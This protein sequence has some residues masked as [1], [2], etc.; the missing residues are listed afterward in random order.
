MEFLNPWAFVLLSAIPAILLVKSA[1][2][3]FS[4]EISEKII[5]KGVISKKTKFYLLLGA[6]FLF[7]TALSRPVINNG[8]IT[9]KAPVQNVVIALDISHMMDKND[10][11]PNRYEFAKNKIRNLLTHLNSQNTALILFD[12][13][14]Y[15][16]SPPTKD[17]ESLIYLLKHTDLKDL[18]R[19]YTSDIQ[20]LVESANKLVKNP[21]IVIFTANTHIP[22]S[23]NVFVYLCSKENIKAPNVFTAE[24]SN[25]DLKKLAKL[26]NASKN[27]EIKIKDKTELFYFPLAAG[28]LILFFVIFFPIR[29]IR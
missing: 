9:I 3:P 7:V 11:Y 14:T 6:L 25:T 28:M 19:T 26:L 10:L 18:R 17:Y 20:N 22:K 23:K 16:I 8:V 15:L 5:I 21:K 13:N 29:R 27:R 24:Y 1:K 12:Q 2:T 4:K